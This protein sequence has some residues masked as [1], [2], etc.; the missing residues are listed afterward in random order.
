MCCFQMYLCGMNTRNSENEKW[1]IQGLFV[2]IWN[3]DDGNIVFDQIVRGV[4][5]VFTYTD[6]WK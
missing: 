6:T 2:I 3:I 5:Q 4:S 1:K